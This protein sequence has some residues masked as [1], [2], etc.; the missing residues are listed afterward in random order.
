MNEAAAIENQKIKKNEAAAVQAK[1]LENQKRVPTEFEK[2]KLYNNQQ[3]NW[4]IFYKQNTTNFFKDRHWMTIEFPLL[5]KNGTPRIIFEVGCGVGNALYPIIHTNPDFYKAHCCDFSKRAV[6]FVIANEQFDPERINAFVLDLTKDDVLQH[7]EEQSVDIITCIFV[8][9]AIPPE[10]FDFAIKQL[11]SCL[12]PGG[13]ILFRDYGKYDLA[14]MRFK[15][16]NY[17]DNDLYA[18]HDGTFSYFFSKEF[19]NQRCSDRFMVE[20][21]YVEKVVVNRNLNLE[22]KRVF[23]QGKLIKM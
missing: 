23:V 7:V 15:K 18:R 6:D 5:L 16:D 4:D 9:S 13:Y 2:N 3:R 1:V 11:W 10:K 8:L 19:I 21:D 17:V 22:M 12:K 14:Q 20:V